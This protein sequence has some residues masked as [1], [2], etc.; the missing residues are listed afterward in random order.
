M[1]KEERG[2]SSDQFWW[3][4][5]RG[6]VLPARVVGMTVIQDTGAQPRPKLNPILDNKVLIIDE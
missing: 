1:K 2:V 6:R 3:T 5:R 4:R